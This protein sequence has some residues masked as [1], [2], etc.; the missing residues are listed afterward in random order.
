LAIGAWQAD[1]FPVIVRG[2]N[3]RQSD[4]RAIHGQPPT[5]VLCRRVPLKRLAG[6]EHRSC[7]ADEFASSPAGDSASVAIH[8]AAP[9]PVA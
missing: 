1:E 9:A 8:E 5:E 4:D 7:G 3:V 6:F 2:R